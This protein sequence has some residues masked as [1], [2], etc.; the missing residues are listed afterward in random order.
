[1]NPLSALTLSDDIRFFFFTFCD[2]CWS[3][4]GPIFSEV[5][6]VW[7]ATSPR[8]DE[9]ADTRVFEPLSNP[10]SR[11][12]TSRRGGRTCDGTCS[13]TVSDPKKKEWTKRKEQ[14]LRQ[15]HF[16]IIG[17]SGAIIGVSG[18][19]GQ[20]PISEG[21]SKG[22]GHN[23]RKES[24]DSVGTADKHGKEEPKRV[25]YGVR[26]R[27]HMDGF[28]FEKGKPTAPGE[29]K[30]IGETVSGRNSSTTRMRDSNYERRWGPPRL[31]PGRTTELTSSATA[32]SLLR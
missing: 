9:Q 18:G 15:T 12:T 5:V 17:V 19:F 14:H 31:I 29:Q 27:R 23:M 7:C 13:V 24:R 30:K 8:E 21:S 10:A 16:T 22:T 32:S 20:F 1:M 4:D 11:K 26:G 3:N 6:R 28:S 2:L 25:E